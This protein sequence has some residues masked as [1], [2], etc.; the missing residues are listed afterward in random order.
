MTAKVK[1]GIA[2][3]IHGFM[4]FADVGFR[5]IDTERKNK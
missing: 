4:D 2:K 1:N 5:Y 3:V